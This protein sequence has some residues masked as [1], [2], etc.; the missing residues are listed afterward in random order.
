MTN[1]FQKWCGGDAKQLFATTDFND[2]RIFKEMF[3]REPKPS[4]NI[5]ELNQ[6]GAVINIVFGLHPPPIDLTDHECNRILEAATAIGE[7]DP[8]VSFGIG[9]SL[10]AIVSANPQC[11][12]SWKNYK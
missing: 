11:Q 1:L 12:D 3:S 9:M 10:M 6:A 2:P 7:S 5:S 4:E 8:S